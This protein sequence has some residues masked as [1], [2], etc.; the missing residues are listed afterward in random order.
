MNRLKS[1]LTCLFVWA[2]FILFVCKVLE[3]SQFNGGLQLYYLGLPLIV[4]LII[5]EKDDR[6]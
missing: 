4:A 3:Y 5:F 1:V 6:S 2:N